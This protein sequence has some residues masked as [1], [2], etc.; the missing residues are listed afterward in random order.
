MFRLGLPL[1]LWALLLAVSARVAAAPS[2]SNAYTQAVTQGHQEFE[3]KNFPEA[4]SHFLR[5]HALSP[6]AR[7]LRALG[8]VEFEL[9]H[10][11]ESARLLSD[12]L[13][14]KQKPLDADKRTH[15]QQLLERANGY[16][17]KVTLDIEQGTSVVVDSLTTDLGPGNEVVLE[18]GDHILEFQAQAHIAQK[19]AITIRGGEQTSLRVRLAPLAAPERVSS[20]PAPAAPGAEEGERKERRVVK[21]PWL[22]TAVGLVVAGAAAGAAVALTRDRGND[23]EKPYSGTGGAPALGTPR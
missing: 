1:V 22:W 7:T 18:V 17:G 15:A 8:M 12:A 13:A 11:A 23:T 9:K 14:S 4:R 5:A 3:E 20:T 6:S 2:E 16:L 19:H 21:N 10:Y